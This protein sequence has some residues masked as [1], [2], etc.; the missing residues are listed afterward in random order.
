M[1]ILTDKNIARINKIAGQKPQIIAGYLFG[2]YQTGKQRQT[3]DIDLGFIC[4]DKLDMDIPEFTLS[5]SKF[6][7][8]KEADTNV[9]DLKEKPIILMEMINGTV[10]YQKDINKRIKIESR[11]LKLYEDYLHY[12]AIKNYYLDK[13]FT[14]GIYANK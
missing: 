11:I 9:F 6:F 3:S 14:E 5:V 4:F 7:L 13:S 12:Q 1:N 10:I 2:S 8:P